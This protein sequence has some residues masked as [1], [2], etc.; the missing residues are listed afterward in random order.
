MKKK[1]LNSGGQHRSER[2]KDSRAVSRAL[3]DTTG[4]ERTELRTINEADGVTGLLS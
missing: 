1:S 3:W 4:S 2:I